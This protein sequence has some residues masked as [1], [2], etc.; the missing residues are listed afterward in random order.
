M[1]KVMRPMVSLRG[2]LSVLD[3]LWVLLK[4]SFNL[5]LKLKLSERPREM[6]LPLIS[7]PAP[8]LQMTPTPIKGALKLHRARQCPYLKQGQ[9][10]DRLPALPAQGQLPPGLGLGLEADLGRSVHVHLLLW[11]P[12][13]PL[14]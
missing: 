9:E 12:L 7:P 8:H 3:G 6:R 4:F 1:E 5:E 13:S 10:H 11:H 14:I 2:L